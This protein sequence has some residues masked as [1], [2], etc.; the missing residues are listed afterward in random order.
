MSSSSQ[1][2]SHRAI[3]FVEDPDLRAVA[4]LRA[5][6]LEEGVHVRRD[7]EVI[8]LVLRD[9]MEAFVQAPKD[10]GS[11]LIRGEATE[12][13]SVVHFDVELVMPGY[14]G[15]LRVSHMEGVGSRKVTIAR[16][17]TACRLAPAKGYSRA[18]IDA[19]DGL[20]LGLGRPG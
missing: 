4:G 14:R 17:A 5:H 9:V 7:R 1:V 10:L 12:G 3:G 6:P 16:D 15:A 2:K 13:S 20:E 19:L 11:A 18:R 8:E